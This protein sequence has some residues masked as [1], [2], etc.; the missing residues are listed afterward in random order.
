MVSVSFQLKRPAADVSSVFAL[1]FWP[2]GRVKIYL[3]VKVRPALW[4]KVDQRVFTTHPGAGRLNQT[5]NLTAERLKDCYAAARAEGRVPDKDE[6]EDAIAPAPTAAPVA[7]VARTV[8][9]AWATWQAADST[10]SPA[11]IRSRQTTMRHLLDYVSADRSRRLTWSLFTDNFHDDFA[12]HVAHS[13]GLGDNALWKSIQSLKCFLGWAHRQGYP[14]GS[15]YKGYTWKKRD[16]RLLTLTAAELAQIE[17]LDLTGFPH[18]DNARALFLLQCYTSLRFS[19]IAN[20]RPEQIGERSIQVTTQKTKD[21]LTIPI[22]PAARRLLE[23]VKT[24][25]VYPLENQVLNRH[26]KE[27]GQLARLEKP[28]LVVT[29]QLGQRK[30]ETRPQWELLSSHVGRRTAVTHML[31]AGLRRDVVKR[32]TGHKDERTFQRYVDVSDDVMLDEFDRIYG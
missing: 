26:L 2:G 5:L 16:P 13:R 17:E 4:N 3:D 24:G 6:L 7:P 14:T 8:A 25:D 19:D 21:P 22:R 20:L 12:R 11:T 32:I 9:Q 1:V 28:V 30:E 29:F 23:G 31:A 10:L 15:G 18:L 27:L